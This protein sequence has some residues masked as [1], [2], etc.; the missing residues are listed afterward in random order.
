MVWRLIHPGA[1]CEIPSRARWRPRISRSPGVRELLLLRLGLA[2]T[3]AAIGAEQKP[4]LLEIR[5]AIDWGVC[6]LGLL[7]FAL[8]FACASATLAYHESVAGRWPA[9]PREERSCRAW[10]AGRAGRAT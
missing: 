6:L 5:L 8:L 4:N 2:R 10:Q 7:C 9:Y 3:H 1:R